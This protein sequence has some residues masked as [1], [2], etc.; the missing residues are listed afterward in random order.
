MECFAL[1]SEDNYRAA[2]GI[3]EEAILLMLNL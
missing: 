3:Y 2:K 1:F